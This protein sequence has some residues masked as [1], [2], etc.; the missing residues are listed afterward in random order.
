MPEFVKFL[1]PQRPWRYTLAVVDPC[2]ATFAW[3][4]MMNLAY[5]EKA[6]DVLSLFPRSDFL[7]GMTYYANREKSGRKLD[8]YFGTGDWRDV[9]AASPSRY[10]DELLRFY[11]K[12]AEQLLDMRS[13]TPRPVGATRNAPFYHLMFA[14]KNKFGIELWNKVTARA[15]DDLDELFYI[16]GV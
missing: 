7:R 4:S 13:G 3:D 1:Q 2:S 12:R 11:G 5:T 8:V 10:E 9:V 15:W 16:P 14:S 6:M